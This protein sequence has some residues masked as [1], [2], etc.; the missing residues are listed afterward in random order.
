M[1]QRVNILK[2]SEYFPYPLYL[3]LSTDRGV[4]QKKNKTVVNQ[5]LATEPW[6]ISSGSGVMEA[7]GMRESFEIDSNVG[8][9]QKAREAEAPKRHQDAV[10]ANLL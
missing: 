4:V 9:R 2:G 6:L 1:K 3:E 7:T 8:Q 10:S 5:M